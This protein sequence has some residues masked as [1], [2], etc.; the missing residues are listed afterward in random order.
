V[1]ALIGPNGAGK[2]TLLK[3]IAGERRPTAGTVHLHGRDLK[4]F[5]A[6]ELARFRSVLPQAVHLAFPF[7][8]EEVVRLGV[9]RALSPSRAGELVH[10]TLDRVG[11]ADAARR[12]CPTLSGGEQQ[13]VHLA[14]VL[15]QLAAETDDG[16]S[17]ALLLD[18]LTA[19]LD[20]AHQQLVL[21]LAREHAAA[22][23]M[24][25]AIL[26]DLNLA[27][28]VADRIVALDK[29]RVAAMGT[30]VEVITERLLADVYGVTM[31]IHTTPGRV[32]V[33]PE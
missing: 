16:L 31:R 12:I 26:H 3:V 10:R 2:S 21:K 4:D 30:P 8:V 25:L 1:T 24:V 28:L 11:M 33:L 5:S 23:G 29:G 15:V 14:R 27:T 32:F 13:R 6:R 9:P 7:T 22:G 18:E 19:S 17:R 20:L